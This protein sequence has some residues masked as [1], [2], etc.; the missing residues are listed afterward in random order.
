MNALVGQSTRDGLSDAFAGAGD[1]GDA[2]LQSEVHAGMC[3]KAA[4]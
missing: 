1:E 2:P 3:I 4:V